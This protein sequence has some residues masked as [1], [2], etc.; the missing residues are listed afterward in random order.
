[1]DQVE[2]KEGT[3]YYKKEKDLYGQWVD[4][5]IKRTVIRSLPY[6]IRQASLSTYFK[7][8]DVNHRDVTDEYFEHDGESIL[9]KADVVPAMYTTDPYVVRQDCLCYFMERMAL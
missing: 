6:V 4:V 7:V 5:E 2:V 9:L 3:G 8:L 1:M